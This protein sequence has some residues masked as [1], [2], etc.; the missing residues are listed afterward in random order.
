MAKIG[1]TVGKKAGKK[2]AKATAK[3]TMK[4]IASRAERRPMRSA[5]LLMLGGV[6][7]AAA[8]W[9]AARKTTGDPAS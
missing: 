9:T 5:T 2:A 7:G 4:G 3:H 1:K 6:V 8:G